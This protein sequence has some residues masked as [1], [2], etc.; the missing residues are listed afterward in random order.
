MR[1]SNAFPG[2]YAARF[3]DLQ[4]SLSRLKAWLLSRPKGRA[5]IP[6]AYLFQ[7]QKLTNGQ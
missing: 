5:T 1:A 3:A 2:I 7:A 4:V 6:T